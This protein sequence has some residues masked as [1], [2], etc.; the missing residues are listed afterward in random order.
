MYASLDVGFS[1]SEHLPYELWACVCVCV[2]ETELAGVHFI[3]QYRCFFRAVGP[4]NSPFWNPDETE[5]RTNPTHI[6][7]KIWKGHLSTYYKIRSTLLNTMHCKYFHVQLVWVL[8]TQYQVAKTEK[9]RK[10]KV[11]YSIK[12]WKCWE[13]PSE[14]FCWFL[15]MYVCVVTH[16]PYAFLNQRSV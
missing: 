9:K 2:T 14:L 16:S 6:K 11:L 12:K 8:F 5:N 15:C 7:K 13:K 4:R 1:P 10:K 3:V